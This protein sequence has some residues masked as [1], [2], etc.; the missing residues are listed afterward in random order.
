MAVSLTSEQIEA[1]VKA[2][3]DA[4]LTQLELSN[5]S[6]VALRTIKDL[7]AGRRSSFNESTLISLCRELNVSYPELIGEKVTP[8]R[9]KRRSVGIFIVLGVLL[10]VLLISAFIIWSKSTS[11][12]SVSPR[13]DW[14]TADLSR[15]GDNKQLRPRLFNPGWKGKNGVNVN[16]YHLNQTPYPGETIDVEV[17][18]SYY[19]VE[20]SHPLYYINAYTEW[21]PEKEMPLL[22]TT[23]SGEGDKIFKF[24]VKSPMKFGAYRIRVFFASAF[25]PMSSFYGHPGDN[26]IGS[27]N[28]AYFLEIPIEVI[29]K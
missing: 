5:R 1:L 19:F 2:R 15:W 6:K 9:G 25:G 14:L 28:L 12:T 23:L 10:S 13:K 16:S 29:S 8:T 17:K 3:Q 21:E 11:Q 24:Q 27:P 7:E 20:G 22:K 4:H 26:Q 18:W